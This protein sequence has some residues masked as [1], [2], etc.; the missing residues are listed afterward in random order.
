[1]KL[2]TQMIMAALALMIALIAAA[3]SQAPPV[4]HYPTFAQAMDKL[5]GP[6]QWTA[7]THTTGRDDLLTVS[8]LTITLPTP[9]LPALEPAEAAED[10]AAAAEPAIERVVEIATV[11]V[12]KPLDKKTLETLIATADWRDQKETRLA[13]SVVL[14]GVS[15]RAAIG[16]DV[17]QFSVEEAAAKTPTLSAAGPE[18][19]AGRAGFLKALRLDELTYK[20]AKSTGGSLGTEF[21]ATVGMASVKNVAYDGEALAGLEALDPTGLFE[22]LSAMTAKSASIKDIVMDFKDLGVESSGRLTVTSIEEK[23]IKAMSV[24]D[25]VAE[26]FKFDLANP[27]NPPINF[28]LD[29]LVLRGFDLSAYMSRM[30]PIIIAAGFNPE[31]AEQMMAGFYTLGDFFASPLS[32]DEIS[33]SGLEI[34]VADILT[35]KTAEAGVSGAYRAGQIP[36][37]HKSHLKDLEIILPQDA[38]KAAAD[39]DYL[40]LY[41]IGQRFGMTRFIINS[42]TEGRYDP[43][44]GEVSNQLKRLSIKDLAEI[45]GSSEMSGLT[46]ER[47]EKLSGTPLSMI[48][49][50]LMAPDAVFGEVALHKLNVKLE[51]KGLT[52]RLFGYTAQVRSEKG[53]DRVS[54][55]DVRQQL[56]VDLPQA[57]TQVGRSYLANPEVLGQALTAFYT[58]PG[59]LELNLAA[60]PPLGARA[61]I[62]GGGDVNQ[63][64]NSL[65][66]SV[67]ANGEESP[68]LKFAISN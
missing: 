36:A 26:D 60:D 63:I 37:S 2:K 45:T 1:M 14:K 8:G 19:P 32:L 42:E 51:D 58:K 4:D 20:K 65:N 6:G 34:N 64:L 31:N 35:V 16:Q 25:L 38:E 49:L 54:A 41:T 29:K 68:A 7:K 40:K 46:P 33:F 27:Q 52:N 44:T 48:T 5:A 9:T 13:D 53:P 39:P 55:E 23:D 56:L 50:A 59:S 12:K 30:M 3:C 67:S 24:G 62:S 18:A 43:K 10:E 57:M 66:I 15:L 11:E 17:F 47:L 61:I 28:T 21:V 22:V